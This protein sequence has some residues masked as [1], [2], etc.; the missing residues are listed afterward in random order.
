MLIGCRKELNIE[1]FVFN[2]S[3]YMPELRIEALIL[4]HDSTAIVRIDQSYTI[5]DT[6]LYDCLDNDFGFISKDSCEKIDF[7][8]WHGKNNNLLGNCGDWNPFIHDIG[9][10]GTMS[11]DRNFDGDYDDFGDIAPDIDGTEKNGIPDCGEPNVDNYSE[12]LP[13]VHNSVCEVVII[14]NNDYN[15]LDSCNLSFSDLGGQFYNEIFTGKSKPN[16]EDI[17]LINYGAYVPSEDCNKEFWVDYLSEY[18]F[19]AD[20]SNSKFTEI[21]KSKQPISLSRPVVFFLPSDSLNMIGCSDYNCLISQSS[22]SDYTSDSLLYFSRYSSNSVIRYASILPSLKY[23]AVQ[24]MYDYRN[25]TYKYYHG[26]PAIGTN[27]FNAM[28]SVSFMQETIVSEFY[29]GYG[30][31]SWDDAELRTTDSNACESPCLYNPEGFCDINGNGSW[32]DKEIYADDNQN[33]QWDPNEYFID[34]PDNFPDIDTYYYEI[35][36]FSESYEN[37]YFNDLFYLNDLERSNLRDVNGEAVLGAFG[38]MTSK[39]IYFKIIDCTK[40]EQIDCLENTI[41]KS[42][43]EWKAEASEPDACNLF[44]G[45]DC[46]S[47]SGV[48]CECLE[49]ICLPKGFCD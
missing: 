22:I 7:A 14:K 3:T 12:I 29:D 13:S 41:T 45:S 47:S 49:Q 43:C 35:F 44:E 40:H 26:H 5:T 33:G 2:Y 42:V 25:N 11:Q 31:G 39:K 8:F 1:E 24:Y 46:Y 21:V 27:M 15:E 20:C 18:S 30:N 34:R 48:T 38:S 10:D 28:D 16:I 6:S 9:S 23:Q 19:V 17:K 32:D 36:T 4:P 37:Y